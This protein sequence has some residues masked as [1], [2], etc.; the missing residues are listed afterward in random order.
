MGRYRQRMPFVV[1]DIGRDDIILGG[2]IL[3]MHEGGFG[4]AGSG[5]YKL[6]MDGVE[7]LI[8]WIGEHMAGTQ[9][10]AKRIT[11]TK[12]ILKLFR[13]YG[14]HMFTGE[15]RCWRFHQPMVLENC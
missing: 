3:E 2:E 11:G 9:G 7:Y 13:D 12:R 1:A 14:E 10:N 8:P 5:I 4:P 15:T 6:V